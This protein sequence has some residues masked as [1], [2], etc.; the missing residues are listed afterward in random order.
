M[1]LVLVLLLKELSWEVGGRRPLIDTARTFGLRVV[2]V[3]E[4]KLGGG[5]EERVTARVTGGAVRCCQPGESQACGLRPSPE[6]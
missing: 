1:V 3:M 6:L 4:G 2:G 5:G